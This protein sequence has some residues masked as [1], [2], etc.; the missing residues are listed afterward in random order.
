MYNLAI[1]LFK[2]DCEECEEAWEYVEFLK[3]KVSHKVEEI[4]EE[5]L[6]EAK[7]RTIDLDS[8]VAEAMKQVMMMMI[9]HLVN[10]CNIANWDG[11]IPKTKSFLNL[12]DGDARIPPWKDQDDKVRT[13]LKIRIIMPRPWKE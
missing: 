11:F 10:S 6:F 5:T 8:T 2:D 9:V 7:V 4:L 12:G 13:W 3:E 1:S